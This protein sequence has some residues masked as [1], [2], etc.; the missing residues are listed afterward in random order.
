[1]KG[2]WNS[3][4]FTGRPDHVLASKFKAVKTKLQEWRK[5]D[6]GNLGNQRK[7]LLE[8]MAVIDANREGRI[9]TEKEITKKAGIILEY[10]ELVKREE[11]LWS[12]KSRALWVT[13]HRRGQEH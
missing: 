6:A 11:S 4:D 5:Y 12:Q 10:V 3:F 13:A 9:L 2:W 1:M 7:K 8:Q